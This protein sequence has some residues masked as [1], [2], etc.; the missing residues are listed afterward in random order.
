MVMFRAP[1]ALHA[2]KKKRNV[3]K[4]QREARA[5]GADVEHPDTLVEGALLFGHPDFPDEFFEVSSAR[6][7]AH[8][9]ARAVIR[10]PWVRTVFAAAASPSD[11]APPQ[12]MPRDPRGPGRGRAS[13][14]TSIAAHAVWNHAPHPGSPFPALRS[15]VLSLSLPSATLSLATTASRLRQAR[16]TTRYVLG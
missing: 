8:A 6:P 10:A 4:F 5:H 15:A 14:L 12:S 2:L 13:A 1:A 3:R 16:E 7:H 9:A 11:A